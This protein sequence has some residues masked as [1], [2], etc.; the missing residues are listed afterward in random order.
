MARIMMKNTK[1]ATVEDVFSLFI[2]AAT[3]RG[4]KDKTI[5]TYRQ[6][7]RAISKRLD[8]SVP[9]ADLTKQDLDNMIFTMRESDLSERSISSYTR[10]LK[11]FLSWCNEEG[12][13][14][15]NVPIYKAGEAVK[16]TYTDEEL[17]GIVADDSRPVFAAVDDSGEM[18]G[19]AFCVL[20]QHVDHHILT[21]IRTLY[22]D[23]LCVDETCRGQHI[24][25]ALYE[26][27]LAFAR[28][29]G[30]YNVT[31]NVW[32]CNEGARRFYEVHGFTTNGKTKPDIEPIEICYEKDL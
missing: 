11:V 2:A 25:K 16:E 17:L 32:A 3:T 31:L 6:H 15:L 9:I 14:T 5:T 18:L 23:D 1:T 12:H 21:D 28:S 26:H 19:Y 10:T 7:F 29:V 4:V 27:V 8:V 13:T 22:I 24:G 20:E 30:C